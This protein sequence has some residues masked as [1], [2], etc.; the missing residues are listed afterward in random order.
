M[1]ATAIS[2]LEA[3]RWA[4]LIDSFVTQAERLVSLTERLERMADELDPPTKP[5]LKVVLAE[6]NDDA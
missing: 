1:A 3:E 6:R 4:R 5:E 2:N